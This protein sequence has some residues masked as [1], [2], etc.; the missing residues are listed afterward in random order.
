MIAK[1]SVEST[2]WKYTVT[3]SKNLKFAT[4]QSVAGT[5]GDNPK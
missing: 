5:E 3:V 1:I 2:L 4:H